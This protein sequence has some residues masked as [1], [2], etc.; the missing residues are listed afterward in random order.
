MIFQYYPDTD[1]LY[2]E[3]ANGVSTESEDV[4]PNIVLNFDDTH[5][6]IGIK[7]DNASKFIDLSRLEL[8]AL[9]LADLLFSKALPNVRHEE[10]LRKIENRRTKIASEDHFFHFEFITVNAQGTLVNQ[11]RKQARYQTEDLGN[12]VILDMVYIPGG[13]FIMGSKEFSDEQPQHTVTIKPFY[14]S[15]YPITQVQWQTV[16]GNNP[17]HF[18]SFFKGA[19]KR[20]VECVLWDDA[21]DF[22][23]RLSD[24]TGNSYSLPSE[25]EWEY[26]CRAGTTT[27]YHY[28][29]I[30][31]SEVAKYGGESN[32]TGP[33]GDHRKGTSDVGIFSPNAF[34]LYDMHGNVWE[35]CAD[36]WHDNYEGAPTD[37]SVWEEDGEPLHRLLRGGSWNSY[38][39]DCRSAYRDKRSTISQDLNVGL[40]L[41]LEGT[42]WT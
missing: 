38:L 27:A 6:V 20:P 35:W 7:F 22:C 30:I 5:Q 28:G 11:E 9:P 2:L 25:A 19:R 34:G 16:M 13:T 31:S 39:G 21:V 24:L 42:A 33:K 14:M 8:S 23:Q 29:D 32:N 1:M 36:P 4:A 10:P 12:G 37:G 26:A 3:L 41:V 15:K 18:N 40:R 17:S